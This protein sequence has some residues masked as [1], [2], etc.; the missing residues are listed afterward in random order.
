[1][2]IESTM[3][4]PPPAPENKERQRAYVEALKSKPEDELNFLELLTI[5]SYEVDCKYEEKTKK[6]L[7]GGAK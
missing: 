3:Q 7:R 4:S 6:Q 5:F 1:M 2:K